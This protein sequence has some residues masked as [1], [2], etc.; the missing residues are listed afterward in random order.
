MVQYLEENETGV[1]GNGKHLHFSVNNGPKDTHF[2]TYHHDNSK[3]RQYSDNPYMYIRCHLQGD[4]P[5]WN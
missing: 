4:V 3:N 1:P 2:G 5:E